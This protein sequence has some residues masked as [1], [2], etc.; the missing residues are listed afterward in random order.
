MLSN[1][2]LADGEVE[3]RV[4]KWVYRVLKDLIEL[5][6]VKNMMY[7]FLNLVVGRKILWYFKL[8]ILRGL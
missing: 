6:E 5:L 8:K 4:I 3:N 2:K 1:K 7:C